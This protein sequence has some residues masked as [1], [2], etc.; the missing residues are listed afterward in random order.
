MKKNIIRSFIAMLICGIFVIS[1]SKKNEDTLPDPNDPN[2]PG[3]TQCDTTNRKYATDV[4]PILQAN[5]YRCHGSA[6]N[7]G[8][9]GIVL[10][11]FDNLKAKA[12][13]GTLIG[14][15]THAA[16]FPQ[17]PKDAAKLSDCDINTIRSWINNGTQ[18]N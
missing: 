12:T 3:N 15:L 4:V 7:T 18:N 14:V 2:D 13:S 5:C 17:M 16:G 9:G 6:T 1:C 10:E 11:N 8:S